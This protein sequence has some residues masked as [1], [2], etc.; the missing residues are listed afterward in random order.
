[1]GIYIQSEKAQA[2]QLQGV[3]RKLRSGSEREFVIVQNECKK[4][5]PVADSGIAIQSCKRLASL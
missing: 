4:L 3:G 5:V 2:H 1:M